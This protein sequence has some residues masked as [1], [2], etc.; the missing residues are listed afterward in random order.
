M[1]I[2]RWVICFSR[3]ITTDALEIWRDTHLMIVTMKL[4]SYNNSTP[5]KTNSWNP[6]KQESHL[7]QIWIFRF[8]PFSVRVFS[9]VFSQRPCQELVDQQVVLLNGQIFPMFNGKLVFTKV[10]ETS[11]WPSIFVGV[12]CVSKILFLPP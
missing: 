3:H 8:Q 2:C 4:L 10:H 5:P 7:C 6:L 9:G 12:L 11:C 1:V